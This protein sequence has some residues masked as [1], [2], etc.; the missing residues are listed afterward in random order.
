MMVVTMDLD[1]EPISLDSR[2]WCFTLFSLIIIIPWIIDV[3]VINGY[4]N[5]SQ[6]E[7]QSPLISELDDSHIGHVL[8]MPTL[9]DY[10]KNRKCQP[11]SQFQ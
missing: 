7:G 1:Q 5:L 8:A 10:I 11:H 9:S 6:G 3:D 2:L 4:H